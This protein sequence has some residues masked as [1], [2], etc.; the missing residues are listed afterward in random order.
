[1][2]LSAP[3][4]YT[5]RTSNTKRNKR[6]IKLQAYDHCKKLYQKYFANPNV[7]LMNQLKQNFLQLY[8]RFKS[9]D[10]VIL[11]LFKSDMFLFLLVNKLIK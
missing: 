7:L 4:N 10:N 2:S 6:D 9:L 5:T 8:H 11:I 1:M 3:K